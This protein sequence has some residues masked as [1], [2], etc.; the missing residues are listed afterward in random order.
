MTEAQE[1]KVANV[2][3]RIILIMEQ[4]QFTEAETRTLI[5]CLEALLEEAITRRQ[6]LWPVDIPAETDR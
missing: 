3:S 1:R 2:T 5:Q 6:K 4:Q